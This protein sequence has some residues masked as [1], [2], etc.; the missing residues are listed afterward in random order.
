MRNIDC[1]DLI[2]TRPSDFPQ[3]VKR[4]ALSLI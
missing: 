4:V 1:F 3:T 2:F